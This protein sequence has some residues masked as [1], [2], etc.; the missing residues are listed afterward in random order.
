MKNKIAAVHEFHS[1]FKLGIKESPSADL[2]IKKNLLRYELMRE[3]KRR[4]PRSSQQWR[5]G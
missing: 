4:V 3:G 1:A 5:F 2:G